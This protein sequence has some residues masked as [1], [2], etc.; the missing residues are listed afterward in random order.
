MISS[1]MSIS[2]RNRQVTSRKRQYRKDVT[3]NSIIINT[4]FLSLLA[5]ASDIILRRYRVIVWPARTFSRRK[6]P[7]PAPRTPDILTAS[8]GNRL[9]R[10]YFPGCQSNGLRI[11]FLRGRTRYTGSE[12]RTGGRLSRIVVMKPGLSMSCTSMQIVIKGIKLPYTMNLPHILGF[13]TDQ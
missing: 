7:K 4:C 9:G 6:T 8:A 1:N 2:L 13:L 3:L 5:V 11:T 10:A 12:K